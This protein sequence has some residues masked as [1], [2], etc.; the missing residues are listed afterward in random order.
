MMRVTLRGYTM[1]IEG[2]PYIDNEE[3]VTYA[4]QLAEFAGRACYGSFGRPNPATA[5]NQGY[6]EHI[7]EVGHFSILEHASATFYITGVSRS[8]THELV[9]HRHL[10]FSQLSQRYVDESYGAVIIPPGAS[11]WEETQV[12]KAHSNALRLYQALVEMRL[13]Q[14]LKRKE[15][16]QAAR[17]VLLNAHETRI[18]V[19]G[20][21]RAWR[22]MIQKRTAKDENGKPLAD[23]EYYNVATELLRQLK[24][25]A[26]NTFQDM[27]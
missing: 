24:G 26:P 1:F 23:L 20:N 4:D 13:L 14:K 8:F 27:E 9:R 25:L 16:R 12:H 10:S 6:M 17:A 19:T 21:M 15:A 18:V 3:P 22:E 2:E 11:Q 7:L 5:T